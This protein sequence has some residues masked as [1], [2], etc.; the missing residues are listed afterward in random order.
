MAGLQHPGDGLENR[1]LGGHPA[2]FQGGPLRDRDPG[3]G[4]GALN[5]QAQFAAAALDAEALPSVMR[6][7]VS[8]ARR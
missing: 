1:I 8:A 5:R 7:C 3:Q 4:G 2:G 6:K